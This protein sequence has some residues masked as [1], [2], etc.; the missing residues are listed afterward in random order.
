MDKK[1]KQRAKRGDE[2][3]LTM[4]EIFEIQLKR[5]RLVP[6]LTPPNFVSGESV[7]RKKKGKNKR[8]KVA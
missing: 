1:M 7:L 5:R 8:K 3:P 4:E 6:D 2:P